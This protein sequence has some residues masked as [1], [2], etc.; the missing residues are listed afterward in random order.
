MEKCERTAGSQTEVVAADKEEILF[1]DVLTFRLKKKKKK[2]HEW[3]FFPRKIPACFKTHNNSV[4][5]V[6]TQNL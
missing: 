6:M 3:N 5:M 2:Y 4:A 1:P